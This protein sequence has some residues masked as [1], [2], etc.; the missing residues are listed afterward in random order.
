MM[1]SLAVSAV[2]AGGRHGLGGTSGCRGL[3]GAGRWASQMR[4]ENGFGAAWSESGFGATLGGERLRW[5]GGRRRRHDAGG[6][7]RRGRR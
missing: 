2:L 1:K 3:S 5:L 6:G 7:R 4:R